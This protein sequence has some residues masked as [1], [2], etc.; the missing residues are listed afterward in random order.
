MSKSST[1]EKVMTWSR[2]LVEEGII[3]LKY[4]NCEETKGTTCR[5]IEMLCQGVLKITWQKST[6]LMTDIK[7]AAKTLNFES[8]YCS[9]EM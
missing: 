7:V 3:G 2:S 4:A 6:K 8:F 1:N 9:E 5:I